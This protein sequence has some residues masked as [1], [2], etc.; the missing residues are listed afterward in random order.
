MDQAILLREYDYCCDTC[1]SVYKV[2]QLTK[3]DFICA[4]DPLINYRQFYCEKCKK[5]TR[6]TIRKSIQN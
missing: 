1:K 2:K 5:T 4:G 3:N 6:C